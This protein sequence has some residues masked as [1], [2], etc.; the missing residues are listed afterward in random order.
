M[1]SHASGRAEGIAAHPNAC[2]WSYVDFGNAGVEWHVSTFYQCPKGSCVD[3][4]GVER[5]T[6][7]AAGQAFCAINGLPRICP[8]TPFRISSTALN[9]KASLS[10]SPSR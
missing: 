7:N 6:T 4:H 3:S 9:E 10:I 2:G 5:Y 8:S 1:N